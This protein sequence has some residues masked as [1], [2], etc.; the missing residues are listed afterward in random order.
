MRDG[1]LVLGLQLMLVL[2][3]VVPHDAVRDHA[4]RDH[5]HARAPCHVVPPCH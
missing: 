4:V 5:V 3:F 2:V 1:V